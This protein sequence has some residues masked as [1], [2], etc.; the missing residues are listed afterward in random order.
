MV[1]SQITAVLEEWAPRWV[2]MER[3]NVG[4]QVGDAHRRVSRVLVAF[5]VTPKV[6]EEA[7]AKKAE[8]IITHHPLIFRPVHSITAH[9]TIGRLLLKLAEN[10]I[11][12]YSAHTNLDFTKDGVSYTLAEKLELQK[13]RFLKPLEQTLAKVIVYVPEDHIESVRN[14]M[15]QAGAG[16]IGDYSYCSFSTRGVGSFIGS[17]LSQPVI[18]KKGELEFVNEIKLEMLTPRHQLPSVISAMKDVHPYEEV[19]YDIVY[20]ENPNVNYGIGAI[21][22]LKKPV[23]LN[24]FLKMVKRKLGVQLLRYAGK[25]ATELKS[26]AVC[27][28]SG[29][30]MVNDA[31]RAGADAFITADIKY[32]SFHSLPESFILIDAGHWETEQLIVSK[33]VT[34][35]Q[36][37]INQTGANVKIYTSHINTNPIQIF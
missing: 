4:L 37:V 1:I 19:A 35:L 36:N 30:D 16:V 13:I 29:S 11:A 14:A 23:S 31:V 12:L 20:V 15:A 21:G 32:H 8:L 18:G 28:G 3:D 7:I 2:A 34:R 26:I 17:P 27:G 24:S 9:D 22:E 25:R 5:E 10:K 6:V 33:I